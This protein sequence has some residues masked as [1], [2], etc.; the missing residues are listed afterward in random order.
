MTKKSLL[1]FLVFFI[2][3]SEP[4]MFQSTKQSTIG[5]KLFETL[6]S[7]GVTLKSKTVQFPQPPPPPPFSRSAPFKVDVFIVFYR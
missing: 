5:D 4:E 1:M 2:I 7:D 3:M 6:S